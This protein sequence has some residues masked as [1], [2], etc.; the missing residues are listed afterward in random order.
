MDITSIKGPFYNKKKAAEYCGYA[1]STFDEKLKGYEIPL[2]G[3][4]RNRFPESMLDLWMVSP[5]TFSKQ[6]NLRRRKF[7]R[8]KV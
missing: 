6:P 3:P 2:A 1:V 7:N 4:E 5:E 8:V